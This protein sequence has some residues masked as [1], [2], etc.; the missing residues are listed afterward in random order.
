MLASGC[1]DAVAATKTTKASVKSKTT[2]KRKTP[3]RATTTVKT[4][5]VNG[6][7]DNA[8]GHLIGSEAVG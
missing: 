2:A 6:A 7:A 4:D 3:A 5:D 8:S 1:S